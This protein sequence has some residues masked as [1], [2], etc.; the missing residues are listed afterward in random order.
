MG[1]YR[2]GL[3]KRQKGIELIFAS[4][5]KMFLMVM[6]FLIAHYF[7]SEN[8]HKQDIENFPSVNII[9]QIKILKTSLENYIENSGYTG[10]ESLQVGYIL[11]SMFF[12]FC[13]TS[14]LCGFI[15]VG[16][17]FFL[18]GMLTFNLK[19]FIIFF[20]IGG[21]TSGFVGVVY[22]PYLLVKSIIDIFKGLGMCL[23]KEQVNMDDY[24][25]IDEDDDNLEYD[26]YLDDDNKYIE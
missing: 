16:K 3:S 15:V 22:I 7:I 12:A 19:G 9:G 26:D 17:Y 18:G 6:T 24:Y 20:I 25:Y 14:M 13:I 2:Y 23:S 10:N 5:W 21:I 1:Y 11:G 4:V 8:Y